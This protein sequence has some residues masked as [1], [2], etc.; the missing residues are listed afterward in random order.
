MMSF[1]IRAVKGRRSCCWSHK[2][3]RK[4]PE[5]SFVNLDIVDVRNV[6]GEWVHMKKSIFPDIGS[7]VKEA[8]DI[9]KQIVNNST[10]RL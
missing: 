10:L 9:L 7:L 6:L 5:E 8:T 3:F 4:G 1:M 2:I